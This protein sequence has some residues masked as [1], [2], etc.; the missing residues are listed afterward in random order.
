M[1]SVVNL[2]NLQ[3]GSDSSGIQSFSSSNANVPCYMWILG[4]R[5][6]PP[7]RHRCFAY[8]TDSATLPSY[9]HDTLQDTQPRIKNPCL[10]RVNFGIR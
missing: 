10:I 6:N 8:R 2:V 7:S 3:S 5:L 4:R 1:I 9:R